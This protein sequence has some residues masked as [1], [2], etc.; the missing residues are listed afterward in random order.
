LA[1][2]ANDGLGEP[3]TDAAHYAHDALFRAVLEVCS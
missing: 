1:E 3:Y 2:W